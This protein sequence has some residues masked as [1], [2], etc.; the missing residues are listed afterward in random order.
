MNKACAR[1]FHRALS[2]GREFPI[3][4]RRAHHHA[5]LTIKGHMLRVG[6][7]SESAIT[8]DGHGVHSAFLEC[9]NLLRETIGVQ[10]VD[11]WDLRPSDILHVHSAG[12]GALAM[13]LS[14]TGPK[15][16][17]AHLTEDS[18]LGSIEYAS[19]FMPT[20]ARYLRFFYEKADLVL[21]VSAGTKTYLEQQLHV[22][23]PIEVMPNT[24]NA[25]A[26]SELQ[27]RRNQL[28]A[29][30]SWSPQRPVI[31]GVGQVQ[32]RKGIDDFILVAKAMPAADFVWVGSFLFGPL[33]ADRRRLQGL[34][35]DA[36]VNLLFTG[37]LARP[38]VYEHYTAADIFLLPS[39]Q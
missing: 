6:V 12:P 29:K 17:S 30:F 16:A 19:H 35:Q 10:L 26:I 7:F 38:A 34:I 25:S 28:R 5:K 14:H 31:L 11:P 8:F 15:V 3:T 37:K 33:S 32:P 27:G 22:S 36:P 21:A 39:H 2:F 24:I 9:R 20:I 1:Q 4:H 18:F 23:K 13:L